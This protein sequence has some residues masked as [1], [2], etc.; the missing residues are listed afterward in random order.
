MSWERVIGQERAVEAL[1]HAV[2]GARVAQAYLFHGPDGTGKRAAALALA[3]ALLCERRG[4]PGAPAGDACGRCL[5][6]TRAARLVH[7]DL[8]VLFPRPKDAEQADLNARLAR[9]A[10]EPYAAVDYRRLPTLD[11]KKGTNKQA[12][13]TVALVNQDLRRA[14]ALHP[15]EGR[16]TVAVLTDAEAMRAEAANA[17]LKL[18]EEPRPHVTLVLTAERPEQVLPTILSRC[19]RV[20]FDPLPPEAVEAALVERA[21]VPSGQASLVARMADGSYTRALALLDGED[22]Q[23]LRERALRFVRAAYALR[24]AEM[25]AIVEEMAGLGRE[26]LKGLF[27]QLLGWVRDLLVARAVGAGA[28]LVN[29][30]QAEA[31]HRFVAGVP[32]ARLDEM[33]GVVEE[34]AGLLERNAHAGLLL[35]TLAH[36]LHDAMHGRPR[37]RLYTPLAGG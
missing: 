22:L 3:Q 11:G 27:A 12:I 33:A 10:A 7:P 25:P 36:A 2:E 4:T 28:T 5:A 15:V 19:Q 21:G 26:P 37:P 30:D 6:C 35:T 8:H 9:L 32:A 23:A 24:A 1:R 16:A 20:R 13:Y 34:A 17:F 31:V 18:L 14:L 29:V